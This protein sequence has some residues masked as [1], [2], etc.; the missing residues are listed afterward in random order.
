MKL[1][2]KNDN[3]VAYVCYYFGCIVAGVLFERLYL[4]FFMCE[5]LSEY[6]GEIPG[7]ESDML[8]YALEIFSFSIV[9]LFAYVFTKN[10][11]CVKIKLK[12]GVLPFV[13]G[14]I[15]FMLSFHVDFFI[16]FCVAMSAMD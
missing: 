7:K 14:C 4:V 5:F 3:I 13:I 2:R 12:F 9:Y 10:A 6:L 1:E 16:R 8:L 11:K 15:V